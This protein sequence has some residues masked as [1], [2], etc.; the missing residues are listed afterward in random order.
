MSI[1]RSRHLHKSKE[2]LIQNKS[3]LRIYVSI[4]HIIQHS[5]E[6]EMANDRTHI[7]TNG[8]KLHSQIIKRMIERTR[9]GGRHRMKLNNT[10]CRNHFLQG[11]QG[12]AK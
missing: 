8:D 6:K 7:E 10:E 12:H 1:S 2:I 9:S 4:N 3:R 5:K 11:A